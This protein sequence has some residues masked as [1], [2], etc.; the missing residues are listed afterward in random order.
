MPKKLEQIR[1][2]V[3]KTGKSRSS[4][5]AIA[6]ATYQKMQEKKTGRKTGKSSGK[7]KK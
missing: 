5:Y 7:R 4:S 2:A 1:K 3:Q 6:T